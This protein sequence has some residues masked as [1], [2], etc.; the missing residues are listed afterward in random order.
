M[1]VPH[2]TDS[3]VPPIPA[4]ERLTYPRLRLMLAWLLMMGLFFMVTLAGCSS[5]MDIRPGMPLS[6]GARWVLLPFGDYGETPQAG[7]R[8]EELAS[9]LVRVRWNIDLQ[10]YPETKESVALV[11]IDER[12]RYEKALQWARAEGYVYGLAGS[13]Q[14]WRY[15]NGSEGEAAVG[16]SLRVINIQT[17]RPEW[18]A[19]GSRSGF[20][21]QTVSGVAERLM[22]AMVDH[23]ALK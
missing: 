23:L 3:L 18:V 15:R 4:I 6:S 20:G 22:R 7:E 1:Y 14:E 10:R 17:G 13:V 9:S 21:A 19:T 12:Q 8:A 2:N 5:V 16:L 11:D